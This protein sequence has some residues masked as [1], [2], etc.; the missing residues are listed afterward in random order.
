MA[1]IILGEI[2]F[3]AKVVELGGKRIMAKACVESG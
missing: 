2:T 3:K 1:I